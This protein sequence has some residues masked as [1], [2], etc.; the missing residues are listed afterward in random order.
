MDSSIN[1]SNRAIYLHISYSHLDVGTVWDAGSQH[2]KRFQTT[3]AMMEEQ[4][5]D[6][7]TLVWM[8]HANLFS[9]CH[10][11]FWHIPSTFYF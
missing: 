11:F 9:L 1:Q 5:R 4:G 7:E 10:V 8:L 6:F 2:E 3:R